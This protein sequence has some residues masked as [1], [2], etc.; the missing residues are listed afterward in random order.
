MARELRY[1]ADGLNMVG[2]L[3]RP[4]G[5]GRA[6]GV[7]VFPEAFGLGEH[8]MEKAERIASELGYVALACDLHG[9]RRV[10]DMSQLM[11]AL[12]GS[13]EVQAPTNGQPWG[14]RVVLPIGERPLVLVLDNHP[15][16]I[17]L[18]ARYL[19]EHHW[20]VIGA[21][22]VEQAQ[23]LALKLVPRVILLDVLMPGRDGWD[24][25]LAL[26]S[27][28]ETRQIPVLISSILYEP[29]V[30]RALGAAGY[31]AKPITQAALLEALA[32][33]RP[34]RPGPGLTP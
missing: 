17:N 15:D 30:A 10:L 24:L 34:G 20:S 6:P 32:P 27:R 33:Y 5:A 8:A 25:L 26:K 1:P 23:T 31:L 13:L 2:S 7:L 22:D 4:A 29:Q 19:A 18:V 12:G 11:A 14:A 28:P 21:A 9:D 3:H 16:F